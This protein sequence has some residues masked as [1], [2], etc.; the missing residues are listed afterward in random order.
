MTSSMT[1]M[2]PRTNATGMK[3][4]IPSGYKAATLQQFTPEQLQLFSQLFSHAGPESY[5]SR[6][7][8]GDQELLGQIEE[9][10]LR[11]FSQLQGGLASRFSGMGGLGARQSSG[12]QNAAGMQASDFAKDL[13]AQR[14]GLQR[15]ALMDLFG[16]S[17]ELLGK[18]P[19]ERALVEKQQKQGGGL[20]GIIGAGL[21]GIG[22]F[23]AGGP[24]GA[25]TGASLGYGIGSGKGSN[26]QFQSTPDWNLN[27]SLPLF[28]GAI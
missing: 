21:G 13:Q 11:Q 28:G 4:K 15:Q 19:Y 2:N 6:L 25:M 27:N 22:G 14:Q 16:I 24:M 8:G 23:L 3:E 18:R 7:A 1:G 26:T 10:A 12:F 5:L 17:H 9:P 20:G